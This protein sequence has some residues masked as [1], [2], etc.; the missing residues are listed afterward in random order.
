VRVDR[1]NVTA[2]GRLS[3]RELRFGP[4]LTLATGSNESGKSTTHAALRAG[5]FGLTSGGRRKQ[6]ET[7]AIERHRP[8]ADFA[9]CP[10]LF[11]GGS[12]PGGRTGNRSRTARHQ[13]AGSLD[14]A[15][16]QPSPTTRWA[17]RR[18]A[19]SQKRWSGQA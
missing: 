13:L 16:V 2:F 17:G 14:P 5:L 8:W 11:A 19:P 3:D 6:E 7:L 12:R 1:L 18:A 10:W 4:G 9:D 15:Q